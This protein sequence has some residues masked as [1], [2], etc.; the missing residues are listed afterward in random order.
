MKRIQRRINTPTT[1]SKLIISD[2]RVICMSEDEELERKHK[3]KKEKLLYT[4]N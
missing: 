4:H 3:K 2:R 1:P